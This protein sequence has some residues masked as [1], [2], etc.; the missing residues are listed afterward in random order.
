MTTLKLEGRVVG[1]WVEELRLICH[2]VLATGGGLTLDLSY[3][4]F[5]DRNGVALLQQLMTGHVTVTNCS[6]FV[7]EQLKGA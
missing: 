6:S 7:A 2:S 1:P 4:A 5:V 3:V